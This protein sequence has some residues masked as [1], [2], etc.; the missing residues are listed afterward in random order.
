[1]IFVNEVGQWIYGYFAIAASIVLVF[2]ILWYRAFKNSGYIFTCGALLLYLLFQCISV[3]V[4]VFFHENV[5]NDVDLITTSFTLIPIIVVSFSSFF[6]IWVSNE[7]NGY[8]MD[9]IQGKNFR[10]EEI[11]AYNA[12]S[13]D[14]KLKHGAWR[15]RS[16]KD[17]VFFIMVFI[18][19]VT[20]I[21]YL[22][23]TAIMFKPVY[24]GVTIGL[25]ILVFET[26]FIMAW[27]YKSTNFEMVASVVVPMLASVITML[28]WV[29]YI[30][31][32]LILKDD[33]PDYFKA[34]AIIISIAYFVI[35]IGTLLYMEYI[36]VE[37][38]IK[39]LSCSFWILFGLT[40]L[41][42]VGV[43]GAGVYYT[44]YGLGGLVWI[45]VCVYV[46][47]N[48]LLFKYRKIIAILYSICFIAAG[49]FLL[50]TSEDND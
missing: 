10:P 43:G 9:Y 47:L 4:G 16:R 32:A 35:L 7:F 19:I 30:V 49:V 22:A 13:W 38:D 50:M 46:L 27:K 48:L 11:E 24:V 15:P 28:V 25:L 23:V 14:A 31:L 45:S 29:V 41:V 40:F 3:A 8:E 37:N 42:L 26:G 18:N 21:V 33:E 20:I 12:L 6:G 39:R 34:M 1:M 17:W 36:S 2:Y 44:D 5:D